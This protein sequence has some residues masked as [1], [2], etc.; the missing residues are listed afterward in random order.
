MELLGRGHTLTIMARDPQKVRGLVGRPGVNFVKAQ[1]TDYDTI[2]TAVNGH[3]AVVHVALGWGTT[4]VDMLKNETLPGVFLLEHAARA[5]A[6]HAIFTSSLSVYGSTE[7]SRGNEDSVPRP[8]NWYGA[9]K[10][11]TEN[12]LFAME[13]EY[14]MRAN[15]VRC[16]FTF[17][18]PAIDGAP[19]EGSDL[20]RS[21]VV[22]ARKGEPLEVDPNIDIQMAFAGDVARVFRSILESEVNRQVY[23]AL[24]DHGTFII[25]LARDIVK[26]CG[27]S[28]KI[29]LTAE[30]K[31][32]AA[33]PISTENI[34]RDF[35]MRID[36]SDALARYVRYLAVLPV[37]KL[38]ERVA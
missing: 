32:R 27:S 1:L 34:R 6:K 24:A 2:A 18:Y 21:M 25:D 19:V 38:N 17:G 5:G 20:I 13:H 14:H 16:G 7:V 3:D 36:S 10:T 8:V 33:K 26:A 15:M 30:E 31:P 11:A 29:V 9:S 35:G 4:A 23:H 22:K 28:S 12:Y 37:E